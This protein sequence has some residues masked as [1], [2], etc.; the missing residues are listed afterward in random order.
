MSKQAG[1]QVLQTSDCPWYFPSIAEYTTLLEKHGIEVTTAL[2]FDRPTILEG[3]EEGL[4]N[5]LDTFGNKF[6]EKMSKDEIENAQAELLLLL[7]PQL[8]DGEQWTA[9]YRCIR[10]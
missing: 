3:G 4:R 5:W 7:R 2:L 6:F 9:D 8:F 10:I 1:Q